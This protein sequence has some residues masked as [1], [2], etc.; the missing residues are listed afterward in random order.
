MAS[1]N[2]FGTQGQLQPD[3]LSAGRQF[4]AQ[5]ISSGAITYTY[6]LVTLS[7]ESGT[8]DD[9]LS[10]NS[11]EDGNIA[12]LKAA[13]GHTITVKSTVNIAVSADTELSGDAT[14]A[15]VY[16]G[17]NWLPI[18]GASIGGGGGGTSDI[19]CLVYR[20]TT[21][22]V[23]NNSNTTITW[24]AED[25]D[26]DSMHSTLVNTE[27]ITFNTAGKYQV[28]VQIWFADTGS[29]GR[30]AL[31]VARRTG[32]VVQEQYNQQVSASIG[33]GS[34]QILSVNCIV[35]AGVGDYLTCVA[36]QNSGGSL[37]LGAKSGNLH[38]THAQ[39]IKIA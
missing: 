28:N 9:L 39:V 3:I 11:A 31:Q 38:L 23:P 33:D 12:I 8:T 19:S 24:N 29:T 20:N 34:Y 37:S 22:N 13:S 27:R 14:L 35:N 30:R 25:Y 18:A 6:T 5:T 16:D 4:N 36:Y 15:L 7:A 2:Y 26:T 17:T 32:G 21:L 1:A 10:I